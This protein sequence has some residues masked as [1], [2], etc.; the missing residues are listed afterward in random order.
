MLNKKALGQAGG[1]RNSGNLT[2]KSFGK[3]GLN[4]S[5]DKDQFFNIQPSFL[6]LTKFFLLSFFDRGSLNSAQAWNFR[7]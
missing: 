1:L 5:T 6:F 4:I 2:M 7:E 3:T